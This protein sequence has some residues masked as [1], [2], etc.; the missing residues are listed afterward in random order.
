MAK[1]SGH[2]SQPAIPRSVSPVSGCRIMSSSATSATK[3]ISEAMMPSSSCSPSAVPRT[4]ASML[5]SYS[6]GIS[7][8]PPETA[9]AGSGGII[10]MAA[11]IEAGAPTRLAARSCPAASGTTGAMIVA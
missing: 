10:S 7:G 11:R 9:A 5:L 2:I 6:G 1:A 8:S 4:I 3:T